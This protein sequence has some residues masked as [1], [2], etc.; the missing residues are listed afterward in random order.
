MDI[1]IDME[2]S[3]GLRTLVGKR[4][5]LFCVNYIYTGKLIGVNDSYVI[6]TEP[7]IVFETGPLGTKKWKDAQNL[8]K[9]WYVQR[10]SIESFG[11]LK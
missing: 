8:P 9:N 11:V 10:S 4:V 7:A 1:G 2:I 3:G 5:T 6:L